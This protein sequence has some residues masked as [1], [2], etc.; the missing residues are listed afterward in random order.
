MNLMRKE[1]SFGQK[2]VLMLSSLKR[3]KGTLEFIELAKRLPQYKFEMVINDTLEN[4]KEFL[5]VYQIEKTNNLIIHGQQ[6][7]V[8]PF[9]QRA[10]IVLNLSNK[11]KFLETF[12]L[13]VLEAM[14]AGLPVIV[15]TK[16]GVA[17]MVE[18]NVNGY[19]IDVQE[20]NKIETHIN[21]MLSDFGLYQTLSENALRMAKNYESKNMIDRILQVI[22]N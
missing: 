7:D 6:N 8:I 19:K 14:T 20:L 21:L 12:G 2:T 3:Y 17:E 10:T 22:E 13:T 11:E 1:K 15:P 18:D 9:Y 4:I 16:G 5:T